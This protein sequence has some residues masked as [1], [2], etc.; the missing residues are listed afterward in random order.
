MCVSHSVLRAA[1]VELGIVGAN[2]EKP[3]HV[4]AVVVEEHGFRTTRSRPSVA[5]RHAV[6]DELLEVLGA[7]AFR[8]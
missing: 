2:Q 6:L 8:P 3:V 4:A 7:D 1:R 5:D